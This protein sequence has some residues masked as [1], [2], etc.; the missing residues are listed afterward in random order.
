MSSEAT[1]NFLFIAQ[2]PKSLLQTMSASELE[3]FKKLDNDEVDAEKVA[4]AIAD[5]SINQ[6]SK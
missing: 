2:T 3:N 1:N 6:F 5:G 4:K